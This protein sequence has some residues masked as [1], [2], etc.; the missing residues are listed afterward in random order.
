M[1][2]FKQY[3][4]IAHQSVKRC[5]HL[6]NQQLRGQG[7]CFQHWKQRRCYT[8]HIAQKTTPEQH[9]RREK[10]TMLWNTE[11]TK[12]YYHS[13]MP[14][15]RWSMIEACIWSTDLSIAGVQ[16]WPPICWPTHGSCQQAVT[17]HIDMPSHTLLFT[18]YFKTH[19]VQ[20]GI[21]FQEMAK[22]HILP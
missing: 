11:S 3:T 17:V 20:P 10:E 12:N 7:H 16:V 1:S 15:S 21:N 9:C 6:D 4:T 5:F 19:I 14:A 22:W 2:G 18:V 8:C 13:K